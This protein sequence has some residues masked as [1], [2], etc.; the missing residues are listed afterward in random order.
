M[1]DSTRKTRAHLWAVAAAA[2]LALAAAI[3][4]L[5]AAP[6]P[7]EAAK[8]GTC[9]SFTVYNSADRTASA[10]D[11]VFRPGPDRTIR[12][13]NFLL[14]R[15]RY[16]DFDVRASNFE[17]LDYR[18]RSPIT[19][20][21]P[22]QIFARKTPL[23]AGVLAGPVE[24]RIVREHVRLQR[25][26]GQNLKVQAKDCQQGGIFQH[27]PEPGLVYEHVL[28]AGF[29]YNGPP[30]DGSLCFTNG[31]FPGY[32]SPE[33]ATRLTPQNG[34][35]TTSRWRVEAG[36]RMGMVVGEDAVENGCTA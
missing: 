6:E 36:G 3:L 24:L 28:G 5:S 17:I 7:A 10:D 32:D 31:T 25:G 12:P 1:F 34:Q 2:L 11:Q 27:E 35:G 8:S 9:A 14:V 13:R 33:V 15:G 26:T 18:L 23:F 21:R 19:G 16:A 4:A 22:A 29:R 30:G 20:G